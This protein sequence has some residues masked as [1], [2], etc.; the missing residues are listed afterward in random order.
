LAKLAE[1]HK[2]T[3]GRSIRPPPLALRAGGRHPQTK[4]VEIGLLDPER[5]AASKLLDGPPG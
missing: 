5:V 3:D 2:A 4:L 1:Y